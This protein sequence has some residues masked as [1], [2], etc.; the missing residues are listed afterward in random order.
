MTKKMKYNISLLGVTDYYG[1]GCIPSRFLEWL[2]ND[3]KG[4]WEY[5]SPDAPIGKPNSCPVFFD[6]IFSFARKS[7]Y[8][9]FLKKFT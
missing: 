9:K 8:E 2:N 5:N 7:D 1:Y 4:K 6:M 3:C